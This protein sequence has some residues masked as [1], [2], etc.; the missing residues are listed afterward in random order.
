MRFFVSY[1][2]GGVFGNDEIFL[3]EKIDSKE[4]VHAVE[5]MLAERNGLDKAALSLISWQEL[6]PNAEERA[7]IQEEYDSRAE[8]MRFSLWTVFPLTLV[9]LGLLAYQFLKS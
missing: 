5:G 1:V 2:C 6:P 8:S 9:V 3:D 7:E 4:A